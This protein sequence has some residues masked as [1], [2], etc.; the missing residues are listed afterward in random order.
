MTTLQEVTTA[1]A[2]MKD[3]EL[4]QQWLHNDVVKMKIAICYDDW[5]SD[6]DDHKLPLSLIEYIEVCLDEPAHIGIHI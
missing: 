4:A 1:L 6:V 5:M 2:S 3:E